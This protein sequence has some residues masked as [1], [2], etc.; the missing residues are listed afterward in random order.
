M[1]KVWKCDFCFHTEPEEEQKK[2]E[3]HE[4]K[5]AFNPKA[6]RCYTCKHKENYDFSDSYFCTLNL[7]TDDIDDKPCDSW[8]IDAENLKNNI[9]NF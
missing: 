3:K 6:K 2:M 5:C 1:V 7:D 8:T 9:D 4:A